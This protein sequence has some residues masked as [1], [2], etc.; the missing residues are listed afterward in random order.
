M[1][2]AD[3]SPQSIDHLHEALRL[4]P[5]EFRMP[6]RNLLGLAHY[7]SG[8]YEKALSTIEANY[9]G[10]GPQGPHMDIFRAASLGQLGRTRESRELLSQTLEAYP[11]FPYQ[12]WLSRWIV[13]ADS[14]R[15]T[16]ALLEANG[17]PAGNGIAKAP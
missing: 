3:R 14:L 9:Q 10:G 15:E 13:N 11:A 5:L 7:T 6:Y 1:I 12:R 2:I 8:D 17:L 4:D 16:V